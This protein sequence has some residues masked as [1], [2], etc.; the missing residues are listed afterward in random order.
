MVKL[1]LAIIGC[2]RIADSHLRA[3]I[4]NYKDIEVVALCDVVK[5][6][7]AMEKLTYRTWIK[8]TDVPSNLTKIM[9]PET[10]NYYDDYKEMIQK[11]NIDICAICTESG[12]HAEI[13]IYCLNHGKH[14]IVE[15]PMALSIKDADKM[16][17]T[18]ERNGLKLAVCHQNR[19][20]P[21]IQILRSAVIN[22]RFGRIFA[23]TAKTLWNRDKEYYDQAKWRGTKRLDGGCLMNQCIHNIDLLQWMIGSDPDTI[24]SQIGNFTHPYIESEDYGSILIR[25]KN[26]AIGNIEGTVNVYP[27]NIEETLTII[28]EKGTVV[29]GGMALNKILFWNLADKKDSLREVQMECDTDISSL[30]GKGHGPLYKNFIDSIRNY[31]RPL[32]DGLEGKKALDIVLAAYESQKRSKVVRYE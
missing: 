32:V 13:A 18:A 17:K 20:N 12:Y 14:V 27:K 31:A 5:N 10:I 1:K 25:F 16:I 23:G 26:G 22:N 2:G 9:H 19:F 21:T 7:A 29:I 15:K 4:T 30:Y 8:V 6:K 28:G 3:V 11:E 24:Y